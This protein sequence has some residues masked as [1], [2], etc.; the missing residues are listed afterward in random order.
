MEWHIMNVDGLNS[1]SSNL[2]MVEDGVYIP[3]CNSQEIL[4]ENVEF[5]M[6]DTLEKTYRR[7]LFNNKF[8]EKELLPL[9]MY[10]QDDHTNLQEALRLMILLTNPVDCYLETSVGERTKPPWATELEKAIKKTIEKSFCR[11]FLTPI[12]G[13]VKLLLEEAGP[14][15]LMDDAVLAINN[16]IFMIRNLL[17]MYESNPDQSTL[18]QHIEHVRLLLD[19]G[20][21]DVLVSLLQKKEMSKWSSGIMQVSWMIYKGKTNGLF[22]NLTDNKVHWEPMIECMPMGGGRMSDLDGSDTCG[23]NHVFDN[24]CSI[25]DGS[26][27]GSQ[28]SDNF[29]SFLLR[30]ESNNLLKITATMSL[31]TSEGM[32][33]FRDKLTTFTTRIL[34]GGFMAVIS[35]IMN[36]LTSKD[37]V[38]DEAYLFWMLALFMRFAK[39]TQLPVKSVKQVL[40]KDMVGYLTYQCF[41]RAEDI[42]VHQ[43]F[44]KKEPQKLHLALCALKEILEFLYNVQQVDNLNEE[45]KQ[46]IQ[47]LNK[48]LAAMT[49]LPQLMVYL[50]RHCSIE[51]LGGSFLEDLVFTNHLLMLHLDKWINTGLTRKSFSLLTHVQNYATFGI[52]GKYGRLLEQ[53]LDNPMELNNCLFTMMHHVAGDCGSPSVLLQ[54]PILDTFLEINDQELFVSDEVDDLIE[55]IINK[56]ITTAEDDPYQCAIHMFSEH[57]ASDCDNFDAELLS[58]GSTDA[59]VETVWSSEDDDILIMVYMESEDKSKIVDEILRHFQEVDKNKTREQIICQL[60]D[61][62]WME[63][64]DKAK[65]LALFPEYKP[66]RS[67]TP[68]APNQPDFTICAKKRKHDEEKDWI[69]CCVRSLEDSGC[70]GAISWLQGLF[71]EAA[72]IKM[73]PE[74]IIKEA[75]EEPITK[76]HVLHNKSIP[77]VCFTEEQDGFLAN[78]MFCTLLENLGIHMPEDVGLQHPRIPHFWSP[79]QLLNTAERLGPLDEV[80]LKFDKILITKLQDDDVYNLPEADDVITRKSPKKIENDSCR[81]KYAQESSGLLW[82][83]LIQ[84]FNKA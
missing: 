48:T 38:L 37:I 27:Q 30:R 71:C 53:F 22:S 11:A 6:K 9:I 21:E 12:L 25:L 31:W 80:S 14:Y 69:P 81:Y 68:I 65:L 19:C 2:G 34:K 67:T 56:F 70:R 41:I 24:T 82:T 51:L 55:F 66:Q 74:Y 8:P 26:E 23:L 77:I 52:M 84:N 29:D 83:D 62:E 35:D 4:E 28:S 78:K 42:F 15:D 57:T 72:F 5:L 20:Y 33:E 1:L 49:D 60:I 45:E 10:I 58:Q 40:T 13:E 61:S 59:S 73:N 32:V 16:C 39:T 44:T 79:K 76:F 47:G 43:T 54:K 36:Q 7:L 46:Y 63:E 64:E 50:V 17:Y 3:S 75:T 18:I